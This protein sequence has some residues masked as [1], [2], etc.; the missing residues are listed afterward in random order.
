MK[1]QITWRAAEHYIEREKKLCARMHCANNEWFMRCKQIEN[2][3]T[4]IIV[5]IATYY[6]VD[7]IHGWSDALQF[8]CCF[9][10]R[11]FIAWADHSWDTDRKYVFAVASIFFLQWT[12]FFSPQRTTRLPDSQI[13]KKWWS[14]KK[15]KK[16]LSRIELKTFSFFDHH[17]SSFAKFNLR[18]RSSMLIVDNSS[19]NDKP[20]IAMWRLLRFSFNLV[21]I[22]RGKEKKEFKG[23]LEKSKIKI[24]KTF[25]ATQPT[26]T[27]IN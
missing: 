18:F 10:D 20:S 11:F 23:V 25:T 8:L 27:K 19:G 13:K 26:R 7:A 21:T 24:K 14:T 15:H 6:R 3:E 17:K 9:R 1:S 16:R 22:T 12:F 2:D 5:S 4:H